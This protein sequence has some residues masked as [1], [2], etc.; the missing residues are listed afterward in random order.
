VWLLAHDIFLLCIVKSHNGVSMRFGRAPSRVNRFGVD[1]E[2]KAV[3]SSSAQ[4]PLS[5]WG[6]RC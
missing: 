1:P 5:F 3:C 2:H 6:E 4:R